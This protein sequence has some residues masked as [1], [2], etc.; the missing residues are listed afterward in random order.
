MAGRLFAVVGPS[1]AGKD[2]LL[3]AAARARPDLVLVRRVITR[4]EDAGG[5]A[6]E[7]VDE[8]SFE[9][10]RAAGGFALDWRAHGLRYGIPA[11]IDTALAEGRDVVFN[12]SRAMIGAARH[13]YPGLRVILV[14]ASPETLAARLAARGRESAEDISAR[15]HRARHDTAAL[16]AHDRVENDGALEDALA[17]LLALLEPERV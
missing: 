2:T 9:A 17:V 15:L 3:Q 5:E 10:R 12:G 14:T 7:G 4:P 6:F 13:R 8:A 16:G 11:G 1:G